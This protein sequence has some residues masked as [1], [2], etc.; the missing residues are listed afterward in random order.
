VGANPRLKCVNQADLSKSL[1]TRQTRVLPVLAYFRYAHF[2]SFFPTTSFLLLPPSLCA[3]SD[4][5][6]IQKRE[7]FSQGK[8]LCLGI[9]IYNCF[10]MRINSHGWLPSICRVV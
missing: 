3:G 6:A 5:S 10:D 4:T 1:I 9:P 8:S 2:P 7:R